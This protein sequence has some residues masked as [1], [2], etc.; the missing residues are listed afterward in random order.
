MVMRYGMA[1]G[2]G[3]VAYRDERSPFLAVP[4]APRPARDYSEQ[5]AAA[6]DEAVRKLVGQAYERAR[7]LLRVRRGQ[8]E[9]G[10]ELLLQKETLGEDELRAIAGPSRAAA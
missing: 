1:E 6:I 5:T 7:D 10:A 4:E 8:L 9:R 3:Q 2:L